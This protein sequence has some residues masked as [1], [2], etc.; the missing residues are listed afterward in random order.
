MK[1]SET[2]TIKRALQKELGWSWPILLV[3]CLIAKRRI[4]NQT[5]WAKETSVESQFAKRLSVS[6]AMYRG[7]LRRFDRDK[8]FEIMREILVPIGTK[9][10]LDNL[11]KWGVAQKSGMKKL[12][13]FYDAMGKGGIG[14][15]VQRTIKEKNDNTL[16]FQVR[17]CFFNRFYEETGTPE[18][19]R[20]FC[21]V[22]IE[23][24][25]QAF[26]EFKFHRGDSLENTVAYGKDHC[27]F[28]FEKKL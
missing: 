22:D 24:F 21:E 19:T 25:S 11:D 8:A 9:E 13:A 28:V 23:F 7:L 5:H 27:I 6:T 12:L 26:P 3:K 17:S 15:F 1:F 2:K 20:L 4:Y 14:Q 16:S 18:L 10:Q